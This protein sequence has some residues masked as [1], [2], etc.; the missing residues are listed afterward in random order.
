MKRKRQVK[1]TDDEKSNRKT[2]SSSTLTDHDK[3]IHT[4]SK[5]SSSDSLVTSTT[6]TSKKKSTSSRGEG[7]K[8][9]VVQSKSLFNFSQAPGWNEQEN[10]I[11]RLG[12]MKFGVGSW[13][14]IGRAGILPGKNFAQLYIQTQRMLGVQSLAQFNGIR[15]DTDRVRTDFEKLAEKV[16]SKSGDNG[17]LS[18]KNGL[19]VN[20][21]GA[22]PTKESI[23]QKREHNRKKYELDEDEVADLVDE[24]ELYSLKRSVRLEFTKH[25]R[26]FL[27]Q[28]NENES[29]N[30]LSELTS[31]LETIDDDLKE[32]K[33]EL[34]DL[35][36]TFF[37]QDD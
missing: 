14:T 12:I 23:K 36:D 37:G 32:C 29:T 20:A 6:S 1:S 24:E 34:D 2:Q 26:K 4:T 15:L 31:S 27:N 19:I 11:L 8:K 17:G 9:G 30:D 33:D 18:I 21:H 28:D 25:L 7:R 35:M 3:N 5:A 22:N 16:N 13:S 10:R